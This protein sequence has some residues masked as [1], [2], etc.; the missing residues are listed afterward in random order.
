MPTRHAHWDWLV[1]CLP[2][3]ACLAPSQW[4]CVVYELSTSCSGRLSTSCLLTVP[5]LLCLVTA[6]WERRSISRD[7]DP[8]RGE[9][10]GRLE[11]VDQG[12]VLAPYSPI[13]WQPVPLGGDRVATILLRDPPWLLVF[14]T[15]VTC[16][17]TLLNLML[18]SADQRGGGRNAFTVGLGHRAL[19]DSHM[20]VSQQGRCYCNPT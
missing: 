10:T 5:C 8:L 13:T 15:A 19:F 4:Q 9:V 17:L 14:L 11:G 3:Y 6:P 7:E 2:F 18:E 20:P 12:G 1:W 16:T